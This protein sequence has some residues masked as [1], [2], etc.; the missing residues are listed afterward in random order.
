MISLLHHWQY[1][2][3]CTSFVVPGMTFVF[4]FPRQIGQRR[5]P[6]SFTLTLSPP[7]SLAEQAGLEPTHRNPSANGLAIRCSTHYTYCSIL[8]LFTQY[9][10]QG[11]APCMARALIMCSTLD[12]QC[13]TIRRGGYAFHTRLNEPMHIS[14]YL[15]RHYRI[16]WSRRQGSNP[17]PDDYKS[18]APPVVLLRH[19]CVNY[20]FDNI[21]ST[22]Y[23]P[24][25]R[26]PAEGRQSRTADAWEII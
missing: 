16:T 8:L 11:F 17:H 14:V 1:R 7:S 4:V 21:L 13:A 20:Y 26:T 9:V 18:P 3:K 25:F 5:N 10:R 6:F 22:G 23:R 19:F 24:V 2:G 15:F 12:E